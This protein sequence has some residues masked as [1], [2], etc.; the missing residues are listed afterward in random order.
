MRYKRGTP[1]FKWSN[2]SC[3]FC[4]NRPEADGFPVCTNPICNAHNKP[5]G[6]W[7]I[8]CSESKNECVYL[9]DG[10]AE[11]LKVDLDVV[12][13]FINDNDDNGWMYFTFDSW[14]D[15]CYRIINESKDNNLLLIWMFN[16][17][18]YRMVDKLMG[19]D[20]DITYLFERM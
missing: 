20:K 11:S 17:F 10:K 1:I 19:I 9:S 2:G 8:E 14:N 4:S 16:Y 15:L 6:R 12:E 3:K 5:Y 13:K 18:D 7:M